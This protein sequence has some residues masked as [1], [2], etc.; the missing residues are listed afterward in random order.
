MKQLEQDIVRAIL[1]AAPYVLPGWK[2][3]RQNTG[4]FKVPESNR[5]I[6]FGVNGQADITGL[7]P[8]GRRVEIEVKRPGGKQSPAQK[9]FEAMIKANGGIYVLVN[10]V[11]DLRRLK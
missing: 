8:E 7:T 3:W 10:S 1:Q 9:E 5:F 6:R 11:D 2:L 4:A